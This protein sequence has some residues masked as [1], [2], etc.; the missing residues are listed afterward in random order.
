MIATDMGSGESTSFVYTGSVGTNDLI[1]TILASAAVPGAF[2]MVQIGDVYYG[3]GGV[4]ITNDVYNAV[5]LCRD[6]GYSSA[7]IKVDTIGVAGAL[8]PQL[9]YA[10]AQALFVASPSAV[11]NVQ[12][13][14]SLIEAVDKIMAVVDFYRNAQPGLFRLNLF[15]SSPL[16]GTGLEFNS[17]QMQQMVAA[18]L[19][20][21]Q[22]AFAA[23]AADAQSSLPASCTIKT[24]TVPC[25]QDKDCFNF[26][27]EKCASKLSKATCVHDSR[28]CTFAE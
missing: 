2:P 13:R 16:P 12:Q 23:A 19:V 8:Q 1:T 27:V 5:Q 20:V 18:G 15:P 9:T 7:A 17:T 14:V 3:D 6:Q 10:Q 28:T 24:T 25:G 22:G 21:G 11:A 4:V 26:G